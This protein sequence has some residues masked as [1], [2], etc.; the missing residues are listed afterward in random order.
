MVL[1]GA[2]NGCPALSLIVQAKVV[3]SLPNTPVV[4][5]HIGVAVA[6][7]PEGILYCIRETRD[8]TNMWAFPHTLRPYWVMRRR[9]HSEVGFK[10]WDFPSSW[11]EEVHQGC[12]LYPS[13]KHMRQKDRS[14]WVGHSS[15]P[16]QDLAPDRG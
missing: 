8:A 4:M 7:R 1:C 9:R 12:R 13:R 14:Y 11:K 6:K 15:L 16:P 3:G 5:R 2:P 10:V